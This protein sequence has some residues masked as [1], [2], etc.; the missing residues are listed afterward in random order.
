MA[1]YQPI[2][3]I[4]III[5]VISI[6]GLGGRH[7]DFLYLVNVWQWRAMSDNVDSVISELAMTENMGVE[8]GIAAPSL[9]V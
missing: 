7:L 6:S 9:I 5:I 1:R 2:I 8:V 4:I 3:I